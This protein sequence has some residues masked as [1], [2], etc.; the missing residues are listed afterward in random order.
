MGNVHARQ[1]S[2]ME[3]VELAVFDRDSDRSQKASSRWNAKSHASLEDLMRAVDVVDICLPTDLHHQTGLAAIAAGRAVFMEKP[4][5]LTVEAAEE[6]VTAAAKANVPLMPGQ[7]VRFFPEFAAGNRM[8]KNGKIGLPAAARTRRGG[9]APQ[10]T[11]QWFMDHSRSGGVLLDLAIHDFDWLRWT[12][13]EVKQIYSRSVAIE[14]GSGPDYALSTL[15]FENG[16]VAHVESTWMDPCGYLRTAYEVAGSEG[17]IQFDSRDCPA[18]RSTAG[19][20]EFPL[21]RTDDPYYLELRG[22]LDSVTQGV[23]PPVTGEDGLAAL[24]ISCAAIQSAKTGKLVR[25]G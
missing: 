19:K 1:Y 5:A 20:P 13:G 24:R 6:V 4:M 9:G 14:K 2:G 7:V 15:T 8:V 16:A 10:G 3:D 22:F 12:L 11:D 17:L 21:A 18:I 23:P 25:M